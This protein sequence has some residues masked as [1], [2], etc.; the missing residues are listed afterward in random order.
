MSIK[1]DSH[2]PGSVERWIVAEAEN[3]DACYEHVAEW[4]EC[5]DWKVTP[6]LPNEQAGPWMAKIYT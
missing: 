3:T 2:A 4:V 1:E 5:L 6:V